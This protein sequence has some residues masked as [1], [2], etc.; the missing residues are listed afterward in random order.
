MLRTAVAVGFA[1]VNRFGGRLTVMIPL[2]SNGLTAPIVN[3]TV[4]K[5]VTPGMRVVRAKL[6]L[7]MTP[8]SDIA[9]TAPDGKSCGVCIVKLPQDAGVGAPV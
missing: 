5:V 9:A 6:G 1:P 4:E 8:P 2:L 3:V 7:V